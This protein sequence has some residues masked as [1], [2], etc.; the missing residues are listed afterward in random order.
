MLKRIVMLKRIA[1]LKRIVLP[2]SIGVALSPLALADV[3][4]VANKQLPANSIDNELVSNVFLGKAFALPDGTR[5]I[6]LE[7]P[8]EEPLKSAFHEKV[9]KKSIGQLNAYWSR[10]IFTGKNS[11]PN[12]VDDDE[13]VISLVKNNQ[14]IIGYI[15]SASITDEVKVVLKVQ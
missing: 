6:P 9:T 7:R 10:L 15:D 3:V 12:E 14:N 2:L 8:K 1:M 4:L 11:P 13:E 5:L